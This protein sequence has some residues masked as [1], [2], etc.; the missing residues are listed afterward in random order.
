LRDKTTKL[1]LYGGAA[2]GG[3]SWLG[4]EWEM[5]NC[6]FYP[7]S[8]W[9]I[10]R[11]ELKRLRESTL[12]TFYKVLKHHGIPQKH[13]KYNGQDHYLELYNGSRIILLDLK[14]LPSDPL[15]ERYGSLEFTGGW[16][17]EGGEVDEGAKE[18]LLSR[19]GRHMNQEYD[20]IGKML[21]T[22]N[23]KKNWMYR[24]IYLPWKRGELNKETALVKAL[25]TDNDYIDE[26][27]IENLRSLKDEVK[28]QRLL[29]G[30]WEYDDD[31]NALCE[32][33][34]II[35]LF[36][37]DHVKEMK[38]KR[39]I[40]ADIATY[41]SDK[42]VLIAWSGFVVIEILSFEKSGGKKIIDEINKFRQKHR[43]PQS[44]VIYDSDGV[45]GFI[46]GDQGFLSGAKSF[47]NGARPMSYKGDEEKYENLRTQCAYHLAEK[48]NK[49]EIYIKN[50]GQYREQII[51]ELEQLKSRDI[52][53]DRK[54]KMIKKADIKTNI[55]RSPDF[56]DALL[57]RMYFELDHK[58]L[59]QML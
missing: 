1:L 13:W 22:G 20:L 9:F 46:G 32:Y 12:V 23:P 19:I 17:E 14:Y 29:F 11:E 56:L 7:E 36:T 33:D 55:G 52:D 2:G 31:P 28:R 57:M 3:K 5:T 38:S 6:Y 53:D 15:Y 26:G 40:T 39:Y 51:Q 8:R 54:V 41:G 27:Y 48:I 50:A 25:V 30:N 44:K 58:K 18:T 42:F 34:S 49:A 24:D 21:V 4:C 43:V 45:G 10:G 59:P 37:N 35:D 16:I 47:V